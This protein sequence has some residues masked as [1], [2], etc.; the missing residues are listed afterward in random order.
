MGRSRST[1]VF[2]R[3][4]PMALAAM[5]AG[6]SEGGPSSAGAGLQVVDSAGIEVVQFDRSEA[7]GIWRVAPEPEWI[8]GDGSGNT[9]VLLHQVGGV[10]RLPDGRVAVS[11]ASTRQI[12]LADPE[13]G[14][15]MRL[16]GAGDGP[17]E[18][19]SAPVI[20]RVGAGDEYRIG[21]HDRWRGRYVEIDTDGNWLHQMELPDATG[22]PAPPRLLLPPGS[23]HSDEGGPD[24]FLIVDPAM[25]AG[26][27]SAP[28]RETGTILRLRGG[29]AEPLTTF[30]GPEMI[31]TEDLT[32]SPIY[33]VRS[34]LGL[35]MEGLWIGDS[36]EPEVV[37][38]AEGDAPT[39]IVRWTGEGDRTVTD[40]RVEE[41]WGRLER[42]LPEAQ[43]DLL[44]GLR[45]AIPMARQMPAFGALATGPEGAL[46]IR[47]EL[48]PELTMLEAPAPAHEWLVVDFGAGHA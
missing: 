7:S 2:G 21:V 44:H 6:C 32:G 37:L 35:S 39:R 12:L 41:F 19:G 30:L 38:W 29:A 33:G 1:E 36:A 15:L 31:R 23:P 20:F 45:A 40:A 34:H 28:V 4:A 27:T 22:S 47:D 46:W 11:E 17:E 8:L 25:P 18:F 16:G 9:G 3:F 10:L 48:P 24:G 42:G 26:L 14:D 43:R 13:G 5:T